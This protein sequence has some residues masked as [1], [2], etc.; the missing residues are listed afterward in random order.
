MPTLVNNICSPNKALQVWYS[1]PRPITRGSRVIVLQGWV[2]RCKFSFQWLN[3]I[4]LQPTWQLI[5]EPIFLQVLYRIKSLTLKYICS[6]IDNLHFCYKDLSSKLPRKGTTQPQ[7]RAKCWNS[8]LFTIP[9]MKTPRTW[10]PIFRHPFLRF[11]CRTKPASLK[12]NCTQIYVLPLCYKRYGLILQGSNTRELQIWAKHTMSVCWNKTKSE[13]R[14]S[15]LNFELLLLSVPIGFSG[16]TL[17][18]TCTPKYGLPLWYSTHSPELHGSALKEYPKSASGW[19]I[20]RTEFL[21]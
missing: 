8:N 9:N 18:Q 3:L 20:S 15:T 6:F 10:Q 7:S 19:K 21:S 13:F 11:L 12:K 4:Q 2:S 14:F 5:L 17:N 16:I 1:I